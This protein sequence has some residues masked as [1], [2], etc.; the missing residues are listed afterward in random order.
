MTIDSLLKCAKSAYKPFDSNS[1][2]RVNLVCETLLAHFLGKNRVFLHS[3]SEKKI[4]D[5]LRESARD[6]T[7]AIARLANASRG[8]PKK[9]KP[10]I[11]PLACH[12]ERSEESKKIDSATLKTQLLDAISRLNCGYPLEYIT[13]KVSFYSQD[14]FIDC[15]ALIPRTETELL[16][17]KA[18]QLIKKYD[19]TKIY[20]IGVGSGIISIMLCLLNPRIQIIATDISPT[21]LKIAQKNITLKSALDS[22]LDS[23]IL[24][25]ESDLLKSI[26]FNPKDSLIISNPPYI[27]ED[28]AIPQNLTYEPKNALFGGKNGDEILKEIIALNAD[29]LCCEIG[30]NQGYLAD[31]LTQYKRV[32]FYKDYAGFLRGFVASKK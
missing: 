5:I 16:V 30:H 31:F 4:Q 3:H 27:A 23:R 11:T 12:S 14:F 19:I 28:Y 10:Q 22:S 25:V 26:D 20:E 1:A 21:A 6:S 29:F 24:L 15:G 8:S 13:K 9:T 18:V 2:E 7:F 17:D 32:E